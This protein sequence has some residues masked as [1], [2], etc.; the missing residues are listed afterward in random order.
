MKQH[1]INRT[2]G[3]WLLHLNEQNQHQQEQIVNL[4]QQLTVLEARLRQ[5]EQHK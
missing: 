2:Y 4:T 1:A 5:I 3:D